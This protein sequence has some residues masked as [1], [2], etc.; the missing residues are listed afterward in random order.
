MS[1]CRS[2]GAPLRWAK[3]LNGKAIPLDAEPTSAGNIVLH[4][5]RDPRSPQARVLAGAD[6]LDARS[7]GTTLWLSHYATCPDSQ[8]WRRRR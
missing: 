5:T 8:K 6:L 2:C 3:T 4:D 7:E 1:S